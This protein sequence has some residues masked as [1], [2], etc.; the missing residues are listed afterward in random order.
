MDAT[1]GAFGST[2]VILLYDATEN[3]IVLNA[4]QLKD[5]LRVTMSSYPQWCG[6]LRLNNYDPASTSHLD[7]FGRFVITHGGD[8]EPGVEFVV[9]KTESILGE[10]VPKAE[11]RA[12]TRIWNATAFPGKE[13]VPSTLL[14]QSNLDNPSA[15][16]LIVQLTYFQCGGIALAVKL[17]HP[18]ADAHC[19]SYFVRDWAAVTRALINGKLPP[20]LSPKFGPQ[21]LDR[22]AAGDIDAKSPDPEV[23]RRARDLPCHRY[24]WWASAA[25]CPFP[26]SSKEVPEVLRGRPHDESGEMM[27]WSTWDLSA[28][29]EHFVIHFNGAELL[30]MQKAS[31]AVEPRIS[32]QDAVVAHIWKCV[33]R[34]RDMFHDDEPVYLDYTLG[35]RNRTNPP[36]GDRF[37][38]SPILLTAIK[39][40]GREA[41]AEDSSA[42]LAARVRRTVAEFTPDAVAAHFHDKAFDQYPQRLWQTFLGSR[43]LLTTSWIRTEVYSIDFGRGVPRYVEAVMPKMDGLFQIMEAKPLSRGQGEAQRLWSE[44]GVDCHL[45]LKRG[46]AERLVQDPLL[47]RFDREEGA[48]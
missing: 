43:H 45:Y 21:G 2:E 34:A 13:L 1:V 33:N 15:P 32:K 11:D 29:V 26:T 41:C 23:V 27:P 30:E 6:R 36:L 10:L 8:G 17:A 19:L 31:R 39:A 35:L 4:Q 9:A 3:N 24:D 12:R 42:E 44:D 28:P 16:S 40:S 47:R 25:D 5:S 38:G 18:L 22:M 37:L 14:S 48:R 46:V 20:V 7:R